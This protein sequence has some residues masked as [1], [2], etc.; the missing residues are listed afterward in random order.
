MEKND[1]PVAIEFRKGLANLYDL[2]YLSVDFYQLA[3]FA[4]L[5]QSGDPY[6]ANKLLGK[7]A[8]PVNR[9]RP[10]LV[11]HT[12]LGEVISSRSGS[13]ILTVVLP[14]AGVVIWDLVK[15]A[16]HRHVDYHNAQVTLNVSVQ[17]Q[18]LNKILDEYQNRT[19]GSGDKGLEVLFAILRAR[20]YNV[21]HMSENAFLI[22]HVVRKFSQRM[23]RTIHKN[24]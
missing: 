12:D 22:Q 14:L 16:I 21:E 17:D 23:V 1:F 11:R 2:G 3:V 10:E 9:Y 18:K 20:N 5:V 7:K 6:A 24:R 19:F 8:R 15:A 4:S 13:I